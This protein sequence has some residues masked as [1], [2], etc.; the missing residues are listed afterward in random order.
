MNASQQQT[1]LPVLA[2]CSLKTNPLDKTR[3]KNPRA[4]DSRLPTLDLVRGAS[5]PLAVRPGPVVVGRKLCA[6]RSRALILSILE[7][8]F[9]RTLAGIV[10]NRSMPGASSWS[11]VVTH[12]VERSPMPIKCKDTTILLDFVQR[13][14][15][16]AKTSHP[17]ALQ[18]KIDFSC[19]LVM[20][21]FNTGTVN[22]QGKNFE[23][24]TMTDIMNVID[25]INR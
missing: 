6:Q 25:A 14:H 4:N 23:N 3:R 9:A 7:R 24:H 13:K 5:E 17:T 11:S 1:P 21:V 19:G 18:T 22:F 16:D 8:P 10:V 15:P 2:A 12:A 20:N